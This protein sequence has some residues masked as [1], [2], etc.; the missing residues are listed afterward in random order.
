[1]MM[2]MLRAPHMI[3]CNWILKKKKKLSLSSD[4]QWKRAHWFI[5][6]GRKKNKKSIH[7]GCCEHR[8][9]APLIHT[10]QIL[11][12][13]HFVSYSIVDTKSMKVF[14]LF[15]F[16]VFQPPPNPDAVWWNALELLILNRCGLYASQRICMIAWSDNPPCEL[17]CEIN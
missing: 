17:L 3:Y 16:A 9:Q 12:L 8:A 6:F 7:V 14:A 15:C 10:V 4:A 2:M 1:M 13:S 11:N 5:F